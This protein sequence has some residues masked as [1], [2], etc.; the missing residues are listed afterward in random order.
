MRV[1]EFLDTHNLTQAALTK[2]LGYKSVSTVGGRVR[3]DEE[4]P[5]DWYPK[6]SAAGYFIPEMDSLPPPPPGDASADETVYRADEREP[7]APADAVQRPMD[8]RI[9]MRTVA[10]Y[11]EGAYKLASEMAIKPSDPLLAESITAHASQAG[12][13]WAKWIESEPKVKAL[14][15]RMMIGTPIGEVIG[16]HVAIVFA[17]VLARSTAREIAREHTAAEAAA[18]DGSAEPPAE[19]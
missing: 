2:I 9:D 10:G 5:E 1:K 15:E 4:M 12:E 7:T 13:A 19:D 17:Y 6:L 8:V 16:V 3:R 14:L 18:R 11:I